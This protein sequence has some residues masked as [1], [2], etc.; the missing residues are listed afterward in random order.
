MYARAVV[1]AFSAR[2]PDRIMLLFF[3]FVF[4]FLSR[5]ETWIFPF[6]TP[7]FPSTRAPIE[8][9]IIIYALAVSPA[10]M[11]FSCT[12]PPPYTGCSGILVEKMAGDPSSYTGEPH[13]CRDAR[14]SWPPRTGDRPRRRRHRRKTLRTRDNTMTC[15]VHGSRMKGISDFRR[16]NNGRVAFRGGREKKKRRDDGEGECG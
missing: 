1:S 2:T 6:S 13:H 15:G 4:H 5:S 8:H 10:Y 12:T 7:V 9:Y 14:S 3:I 11:R 16:G